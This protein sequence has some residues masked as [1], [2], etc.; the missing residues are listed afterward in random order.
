MEFLILDFEAHSRIYNGKNPTLPHCPSI[1]VEMKCLMFLKAQNTLKT[2][3]YPM[4]TYISC[5]EV[6]HGFESLR[7]KDLR[8]SLASMVGGKTFW[9]VGPLTST[10]R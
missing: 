1:S 7:L 2:K 4:P 8:H 5:D 9:P 6:S 3:P 10:N